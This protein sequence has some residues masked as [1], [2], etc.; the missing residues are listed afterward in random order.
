MGM[1]FVIFSTIVME[2][3]HAFEQWLYD[4]CCFAAGKKEDVQD[5]YVMVDLTDAKL[6]F[7]EGMTCMEYAQELKLLKL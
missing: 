6:A 2:I 5:V 7:L 4:T 1:R 3:K